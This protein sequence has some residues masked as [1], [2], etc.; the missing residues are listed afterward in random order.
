MHFITLILKNLIR[1][2]TQTVLTVLGLSVSVTCMVALLGISNRVEE[3]VLSAFERRR[4]DLVVTQAGRSSG[5]NSDFRE[6]LVEQA[7]KIPGVEAVAS[8]VVNLI[9]VT[10]DSGYTDQVMIMGWGADNFS[11]EH[12]TFLAGRKFEPG[13]PK[14]VLLGHILANNLG[15]GVGDRV[16]FG[17]PD[18][19]NADNVYEV[20]GVFRSNVVFEDGAAIVPIDE[21]RRLT[22]M[23]V[24]GFS[25]RVRKSRP[26]SDAEVATVRQQ[27]EA[28][29]D[30]QD[31]SVR[32]SAQS[33]AEYTASISHLKVVRATS[34]IVSV[35]ASLVGVI[36][37]LNT[38]AMSVL[39]R[40]QE[41]GILRAVGW[42][43]RRVIRMI[44]GEAVVM[45]LAAAAVGSVTARL[46]T[47]LLT[48]FPQVN[49][50]IEA[51]IAP[52]V[53][54]Q[55][56]GLT[57]LIGL[58]GGLYPAIRASRLLPSEAIRHD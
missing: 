26:D 56:F 27:I 36:G 5:L 57:L 47:E 4:I 24:T 39:E 33:P 58:L 23:Q 20:I 2:P 6:Y 19:G 52:F 16:T 13:E 28:L 38:M 18:E 49:G 12:L 50:F 8:A 15:K 44:L 34:W 42:P 45:A 3:S 1:R 9:D 14:V 17:R 29:R 25:V 41:I 37:V 51:D 54:L 10:R 53:F 7:R 55:G 32:L 35:I 22:G 11:F 30:P 43:G 46:A 40:T 48:R 21:G 31:P